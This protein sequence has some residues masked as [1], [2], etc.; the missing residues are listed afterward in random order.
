MSDE[1]ITA[2]LFFG[3]VLFL[4]TWF[5]GLAVLAWWQERHH[6]P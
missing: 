1:M 5:G 3:T 6:E 2:G 4:I